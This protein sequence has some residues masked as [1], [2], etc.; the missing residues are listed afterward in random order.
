MDFGLDDRFRESSWLFA[1]PITLTVF[2]ADNSS[3]LDL[4]YAGVGPGQAYRKIE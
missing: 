1:I 2:R 4:E 3:L